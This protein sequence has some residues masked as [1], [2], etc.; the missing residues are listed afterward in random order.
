MSIGFVAKDTRPIRNAQF[1]EQCRNNIHEF[2]IN[3]RYSF[4]M[5]SKTLF[6]PTQKEFLNLVHY[7]VDKLFDGGYAWV[8]TFEMDCNTLLKDLK[9][10]AHDNCGKTALGAPGTPQNWPHML[11]MLNWLVDLCKVSTVIRLGG[12]LMTGSR[13]LGEGCPRSYARGPCEPTV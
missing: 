7:L 5:N 4:P 10:P 13:C 8:K 6:S 11:A 3:T 2:L 12:Q 1:Q 9:Y